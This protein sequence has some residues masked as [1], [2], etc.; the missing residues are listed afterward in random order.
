MPSLHP[1]ES[2]DTASQLIRA[3]RR[4]EA[5]RVLGRLLRGNPDHA[6]AWGLLSGLVEDPAQK[7]DCLRQ[8]LRLDPGNRQAAEALRRLTGERPAPAQP[9]EEL[10]CPGCNAPLEVRFVGKLRDKRATCRFCG[11]QVDLPDTYRRVQRRQAQEEHDWGNRT[12]DT[13]VVETRSDGVLGPGSEGTGLD[14]QEIRYSLTS[15]TTNLSGQDT[16]PRGLL[17]AVLD[18]FAKGTVRAKRAKDAQASAEKELLSPEEIIRLAGGPL[19]AEERTVCPQCQA[20]ISKT[21]AWCQ[22]C[23]TRFPDQSDR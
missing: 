11:T 6:L 3:G 7:T 1:G 22:W 8:V 5:K 14:G 9:E 19:P 13:V 15:T 18:I 20:T 12:V 10:R 2:V 21:A 4:E 17:G 16:K 23:G